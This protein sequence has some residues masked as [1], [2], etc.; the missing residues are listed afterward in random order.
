VRYVVRDCAVVLLAVATAVR[1]FLAL[2]SS[3][4]V[5]P[6]GMAVG[7]SVGLGVLAVFYRDPSEE[8]EDR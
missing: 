6:I 8:G 3:P 5:I 4:Y 7:S 2:C 1:L